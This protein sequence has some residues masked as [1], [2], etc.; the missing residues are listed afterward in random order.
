LQDSHTAHCSLAVH[1]VAAVPAKTANK[2]L[3]RIRVLMRV[4]TSTDA[5]KRRTTILR[6]VAAADSLNC[7]RHVKQTL[8]EKLKSFSICERRVLLDGGL[9][10]RRE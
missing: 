9:E 5:P 3:I 1:T 2:P 10:N 4:H 6:L 7:D 8:A